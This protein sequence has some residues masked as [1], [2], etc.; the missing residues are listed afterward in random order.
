M[1]SR[2]RTR[3]TTSRHDQLEAVRAEVSAVDRR[4]RRAVREQPLMVVAAALAAGFVLGR[5]IRG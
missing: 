1:T 4:L 3:K 2:T 5:V